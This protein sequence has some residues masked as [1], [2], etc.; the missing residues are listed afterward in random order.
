M[1]TTTVAYGSVEQIRAVQAADPLGADELCARLPRINPRADLFAL[2]T[3][4]RRILP[5]TA[6]VGGF[7]RDACLAAMRDIGLFAGSIKRHGAEPGRVVPELLP[8]LEELGRRTDM[9]PR[10]TVLHYCVWNPTGERRRTYTGDAQERA[11]QDSVRHAFPRLHTALEL[12]GELSRTEPWEPGFAPLVAEIGGHAQVM[13]ESIDRVIADVSPEFFARG[14]RPY[15]EEFTVDGTAYLGPAAAQVPLWLVD[16]VVWL[17]DAGV[18]AYERF[19]LDSVPYGLPRWRD[20]HAAWHGRPSAVGRL[21][22]AA[23]GPHAGAVRA[24]AEALV[25]LLRTVTTF[26]G[27]HLRI[28]RQAYREDVRLYPL[29]SGGGSVD[30]LREVLLLTRENARIARERAHASPT[31]TPAARRA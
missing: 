23:G 1:L 12:C 17:S 5:D 8:V 15:F 2:A 3:A 27:R 11:L 31:R 28:A 7:S 10:D 19:L 18:D 14:L 4:L 22:T 29:G 6:D 24:G 16:E 9:V 21:L 20:L 25:E 26:R 30:L 13:V